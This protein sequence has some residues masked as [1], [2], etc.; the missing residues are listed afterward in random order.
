MSAPR[1]F[2]DAALAAGK[3]IDLPSDLAHHALR[4]LRL[5]NGD[6]IALFNGRGGEFAAELRRDRNETRARVL[7]FDG[8]ERESPLRLTLIQA[9]VA[10]DKL[11]W[12]VEKAVE[13]G[14]ARIVI[15][16][17]Q[18]SVV[19]LDAARGA[20]RLEHWRQIVR[21]ACSQCGRNRLPAL[22]FHGSL[23]AALAAV[24]ADQPRLLLSPAASAGLPSRLAGPI[25]ALAVGP[26]GGFTDAE[27]RH[28][29]GAGFTAVRLGP[30]ILRTE[31]AG[32][33][34]LAALQASSGDLTVAAR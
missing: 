11:D 32:L 26:E 12:I 24:P 30:R 4:V 28:A 18:R 23:D 6:P 5:R 20:R 2:I 17:T 19:R 10:A 7:A 1:F 15:A 22:D 16:P 8:V 33:A 25:A 13:L 9:L 14:V 27:L 34:A 21:A 3:E 31:T 29:A